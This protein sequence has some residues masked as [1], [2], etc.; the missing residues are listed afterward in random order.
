MQ[1][2]AFPDSFLL[3][4]RQVPKCPRHPFAGNWQN[5]TNTILCDDNIY[6][7]CLQTAKERTLTACCNRL[8]KV[9]I[10]FSS[11]RYDS[12]RWFGCYVVGVEPAL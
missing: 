3:A 10:I 2:S 5:R 12:E 11:A 1:V 8:V 9:Q 6:V 7:F 4:I